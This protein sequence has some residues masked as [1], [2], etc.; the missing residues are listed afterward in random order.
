MP[1]S[2]FVPRPHAAATMLCHGMSLCVQETW[3]EQTIFWRTQWPLFCASALSVITLSSHRPISFA[4][5]CNFKDSENNDF[6]S[7][8]LVSHS[9]QWSNHVKEIACD[10]KDPHSYLSGSVGRQPCG[11]EAPPL[12]RG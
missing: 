3:K 2:Y 9:H 7:Y 12:E 8:Y 11:G 1:P 6:P 10:Y 5:F 4:A